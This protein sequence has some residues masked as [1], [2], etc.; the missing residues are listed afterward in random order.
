M[1]EE[2]QRI[3]TILMQ[4]FRSI[5]V[6]I[7]DKKQNN[8]KKIEEN[9]VNKIFFKKKSQNCVKTNIFEK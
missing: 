4:Y 7:K 3:S 2:F 8:K 5:S 9:I 1:N 6:F